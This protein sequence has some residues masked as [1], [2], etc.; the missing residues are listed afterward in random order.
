MSIKIRNYSYYAN[1][2]SLQRLSQAA[3]GYNFKSSPEFQSIEPVTIC[4]QFLFLIIC[5]LKPEL[6]EESFDVS[7]HLLV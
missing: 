4:D 1:F 5:Q 3:D 2:T 7:F 6:L